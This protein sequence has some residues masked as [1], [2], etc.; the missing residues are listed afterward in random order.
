MAL[1][2]YH[3]TGK[4]LYAKIIGD[5]V[6][7][8]EPAQKEWTFDLV[9]DSENQKKFLDSGASDFYIKETKNGEPYVRFTRKEIKKDGTKGSPIRVVDDQG[10]EWDDRL[11]GNDSTL[12]VQYTLNEVGKGKEVRLKPSVLAVQVWDLKSYKAPSGFAAKPV[13]ASEKADW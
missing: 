11:V 9:L 2:T 13:D 1:K 4:A 5:P 10:A 7:G 8:Y 3:I 6:P 12:N